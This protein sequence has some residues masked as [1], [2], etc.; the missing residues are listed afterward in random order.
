[1]SKYGR[2]WYENADG[3]LSFAKIGAVIALACG[4]AWGAL[5]WANNDD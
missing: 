5:N 2:S 3:D 1:M 4:A